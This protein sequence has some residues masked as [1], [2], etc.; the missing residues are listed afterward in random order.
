MLKR[1]ALFFVTFGL[2]FLIES[3][4][5]TTQ[6]RAYLCIDLT[7]KTV[8]YLLIVLVWIFAEN[9][10]AKKIG[11]SSLTILIFAASTVVSL[12]ATWGA[13]KLFD[14]DFFVAYQIMSFGQVLCAPLKNDEK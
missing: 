5:L 12:F 10:F 3:L 13:T 11:W 6:G 1:L 9:S 14:V 2:S 7:L 8:A 4:G